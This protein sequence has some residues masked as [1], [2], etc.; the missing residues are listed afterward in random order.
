MRLLLIEDSKTLCHT[1]GGTLRRSGFAVDIC[2]NGENGLWRACSSEY[3]V[4]L[5]DVLLPAM[6]GLEVLRNYRKAGHDT[7]VLMLTA[8]TS[9]SDRVGALNCG[10]DDYL[11]KP[12]ALQEMLA[13]VMAL[14]RRRYGQATPAFTTGDL[15][16]DRQMRRVTFKGA[17][18]ALTAREFALLDYLASRT[19]EVVSREEI[20]EHIYDDLGDRSSNVVDKAICILRRK[21][22]VAGARSVIR[23]RR[24]HGYVIQLPETCDHSVAS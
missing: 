11:C 18:L 3:D 21:L 2:N 22:A 13:R 23:T 17:E 15:T 20:E 24:G 1:V 5:L 6:D 7:P 4:I 14:T 16:I 10:A 12:F 9:V 19:G 8:K